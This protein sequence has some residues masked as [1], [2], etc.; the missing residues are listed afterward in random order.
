MSYQ[1]AVLS[2]IAKMVHGPRDVMFPQYR[3]ST[4]RECSFVAGGLPCEMQ[5]YVEKLVESGFFF[6]KRTSE[7]ISVACFHCGVAIDLPVRLEERPGSQAFLQD[8]WNAHL[9]INPH[10]GYAE[11]VKGL[12]FILHIMNMCFQ[13]L[14]VTRKICVMPPAVRS[15]MQCHV[16]LDREIQV[17]I[18]PCGHACSCGVCAPG[19][20]RCPVCR[21][22]C[23]EKKRI[24]L[25]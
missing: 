15:T 13:S 11:Y 2:E 21:G 14:G 25:C 18:L 6:L 16:C 12:P 8:P 10:C 23:V 20:D 5:S 22:H 19:L 9:F 4:A 17:A 7:C 24:Y 3:I 1:S